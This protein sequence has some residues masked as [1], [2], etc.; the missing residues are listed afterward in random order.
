[1][2]FPLGNIAFQRAPAYQTSVYSTWVATN[3]VDG[4]L[5]R[6]TH[7]MPVTD[8]WFILDMRESVTV[9]SVAVTNRDGLE[10]R[11]DDFEIRVG[12][13]FTT[14]GKVNE[15]CSGPNPGPLLTMTFA[16]IGQPTGRYLSV[17]IYGDGRVLTICELA[18]YGLFEEGE[19]KVVVVEPFNAVLVALFYSHYLSRRL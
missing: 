17:H 1:M 14:H 4:D 11:L 12:N 9:S 2:N 5:G 13:S 19:I 6:C 18:V 15:K 7:T 16:C 3:A 10:M 8:P